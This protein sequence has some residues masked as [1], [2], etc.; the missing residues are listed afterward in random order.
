MLKLFSMGLKI[1]C[2][3]CGS[4]ATIFVSSVL[5]NRVKYNCFCDSCANCSEL[6]DSEGYGLIDSGKINSLHL[7]SSIKC[8]QCGISTVEFEKTIKLGCH[9]CYD[10][11]KDILEPLLS[12]IHSGSTHMGKIPNKGICSTSELQRKQIKLLERRLQNVVKTER[13]D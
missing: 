8:E 11:F 6:L 9:N 13:F 10:V 2:D 12:R 3:L 7:R 4:N 1:K 5:S